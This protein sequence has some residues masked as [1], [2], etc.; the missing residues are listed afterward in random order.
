MTTS[1]SISPKEALAQ[2]KE[3]MQQL[4]D[5]GAAQALLGW[6]MET[7]MPP[8]AAEARGRQLSTLAAF[9]HELH[10]ANEVGLWIDQ[11]QSFSELS[12]TDKAL[13]RVV[14][15]DYE[16]DKKLSTDLVARLSKTTAEAHLVWIDARKNN[17]FKTFSPVLSKIIDLNKEVAE[18]YGYESSPYDALMDIYEPDLTVAQLDPLF[19]KLKTELVE[20]LNK[21]GS[22]ESKTRPEFL[23]RKFDKQKQL[24][25]GLQVLEAMGFDL[26]AGRQDLA[27]HPFCSGTAIN[28]VRLTTRVDEHD[29]VSAL[30]SSMHEGG[31]GLYEQG[32]DIKLDGTPLG[33]GTSLG[34][35]ESQSRLWENLIGRS[36]AFW[37]YFYP[38][39]QQHFAP[40]L[41]DISLDEFYKG[42]N[43]VKPSLIR[44]ESDELTY[45][46][47]ILLRYEIEKDL[48]EGKLKVDEIP[49][50]WNESMQSLLGIKPDS[51]AN[52]C[53][54]D[55]H[56]S[57]G[58]FGYFPTY[59]LGNIYSAQF[60]NAAQKAMPELE[61]NI[62]NG[63]LLGLRNWLKENIHHHGK[64]L[65]PGELVQ[66]VCGETMNADYLMNY[67]REKYLR[68]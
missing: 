30:F 53:L 51:D 14:K 64:C 31:H 26:E 60:Y 54:Q 35:H 67:F 61:N 22:F 37:T 33:G 38:K 68:L 11:A 6:D 27:P 20:I 49:E 15:K 5:I 62:Q 56:W 13:L 25:F 29:L 52:G 43:F 16:R 57:H 10:T 63:Q 59:T 24:D 21:L 65:T 34:I 50:R 1:T 45:N 19:S 48:I 23:S 36:K 3:R 41:D 28:D 58:S 4:S 7:M 2:L 46:L 44:V 42:V 32:I 39:L 55:I 40:T 8:K 17:S 12:A 18:A 47:H 9:S 66:Q